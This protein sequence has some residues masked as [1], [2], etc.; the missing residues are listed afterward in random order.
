MIYGATM[1]VRIDAD[2][3]V[4]RFGFAM[5]D[6]TTRLLFPHAEM[7]K[8]SGTAGD[9]SYNIADCAFDELSGRLDTL[10][11]HADA[12]SL[13]GVVL[14][15][16][17]S[18]FQL[19]IARAEFPRGV[20]LVRA[21]SGV[22][23]LA[24]HVSL[25]DVELSYR[26]PFSRPSAA[27]VAPNWEATA[28]AAVTDPLSPPPLRQERL[29]F[30]DGLT[31]HVALTL[32]VKLDLPLIG[33]RTLDQEL[34]IAIKDG[35]ID[36][37]ALDEG[38]NWLEGAFLDIGVDRG[39]LAVSW[40]VPIVAP[41]RDIVS[42]ALDGQAQTLATFGRVPVRSFADYR[43]GKGTEA[44]HEKSE[45]DKKRS[46][47]R[48]LALNTIDIALSMTAPRSVEIGGG[49]VMF[50][51]DDAP[52]LVDLKVTG[53]IASNSAGDI[54][55]A[56]SAIDTT[57]KDVNFGG[58]TLSSDRMSFDGIDGFE[59]TFDGFKPVALTMNIH[60]ATATNLSVRIGK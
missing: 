15:T 58:M 7:H 53:G 29:Q 22:E 39:R 37:R 24:P 26:G 50:G 6:S 51:G 43:I 45:R 27:P 48:S 32:Q 10:R 17:L 9:L 3:N 8:L 1:A 56:I 13:G 30:L 52:G 14:A 46:M 20:L 42:C 31:G 25:A 54:K 16:A 60:R 23:L 2:L 18:D 35:S 33:N 11:W 55:G 38:L 28:L 4:Q 19:R 40:G 44:Q 57:F 41:S 5:D 59:L 47:L 12:A 49:T 34:N 21:A 36:F